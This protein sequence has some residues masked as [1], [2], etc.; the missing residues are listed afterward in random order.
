MANGK[1]KTNFWKIAGLNV[2]DSLGYESFKGVM[3]AFAIVDA[4]TIIQ[5]NTHL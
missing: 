3:A 2:N 1:T 5:V 4:Q